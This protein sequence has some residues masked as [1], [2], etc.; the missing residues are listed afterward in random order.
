[1]R[2]SI[3]TSILMLFLSCNCHAQ[4][5]Q[6]QHV[7]EDGFVWY[8]LT[9]NISQHGAENESGGSIVPVGNYDI[10]YFNG[11][12]LLF[13]HNHEG[14]YSKEGKELIPLSSQYEHVLP[15][16]NYF[17]IER[18]GK[19]GV[20]D[21]QGE[22]IIPIDKGYSDIVYN[23]TT[24]FSYENSNGGYTPLGLKLDEQ[25]KAYT[26]DVASLSNRPEISSEY[27]D[28]AHS[29]SSATVSNKPKGTSTLV[30]I[31]PY[32]TFIDING[33]KPD[34]WNC[35]ENRAMNKRE[36]KEH[37]VVFDFKGKPGHILVKHTIVDRRTDASETRQTFDIKPEESV[38][39]INGDRIDIAFKQNGTE[40]CIYVVKKQN[41]TAV[42]SIVWGD[43]VTN[44]KAY[45]GKLF[46]SLKDLLEQNKLFVGENQ[47]LILQAVVESWN[48]SQPA[49]KKL[50]IDIPDFNE[51]FNWL[52]QE[53][54]R[55]K[56]KKS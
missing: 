40:K 39:F 49:N 30:E 33:G 20:C 9:R 19:K 27:S 18:N 45:N 28:E 37:V 8:E 43:M 31:F 48:K 21:I 10:M 11:Y 4:V 26:F 38:L 29:D 23:E 35:L 15:L 42:E 47:A 6:K 24:G 54:L 55:Y 1:M 36:I 32:F 2:T 13:S 56:W 17:Q 3:L 50:H 53:L 22:E 25:G 7:E 14:I 34:I 16:D 52:S 12:F 5:G 41:D 51:K 44:G 46:Q